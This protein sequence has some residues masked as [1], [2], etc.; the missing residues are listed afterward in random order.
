MDAASEPRSPERETAG[1]GQFE[2]R[3]VGMHCAGCVASIEKAVGDL[4]GV[5]R[6]EVSLLTGDLSV[7]LAAS[8]SVNS[9]LAADIAGAVE[10][11]GPYR[12]ETASPAA[13]AEPGDS[14]AGSRWRDGFLPVAGALALAGAAMAVAMSG[15]GAST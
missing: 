13:V 9:S 1:D 6:A 7:S 11:A 3:V 15:F 2:A 8:R 14:A 10:S 5:E 12:V 4:P